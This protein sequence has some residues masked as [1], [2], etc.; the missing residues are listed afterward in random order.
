MENHTVIT[1]GHSHHHHHG[2]MDG[3]HDYTEAVNAYRKT[4]PNKQKVLEQTPDP[5]VRE[6][7]LHLQEMGVETVFDRFDSQQPQCP[8]G[9]A[10]VCCKNCYMGPCKITKKCPRGV[11]GADADVIVARNM[12]RAAA[13][14]AAAH[15]ARGR[16]SM[17]ALKKAGEGTVNLPIEGEAKIRAVCDI[18]GIEAEGKSINALAVEVADILLEDLSRTVPG[19]HRTLAAFAPEERQDVWAALDI[20]PVSVYHEVFESLHRTS[21]GTDGDWRNIMQQFL[22]TGLA[23]AWTSCLGSS[24]AMDSLYGLPKRSR[25]KMN[26]GA[27]KKGFVNIAFLGHSPLFFRA[28]VHTGKS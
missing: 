4:F 12:L 27:L 7:L 10:G 28:I 1:E 11:C 2:G 13:A 15:G 9:I 19:E 8:F 22:R 26:L 14:G 24:I 3:F 6:M 5:A 23:F 16:E 18:Y 21:T 17:L 20:L 25:S